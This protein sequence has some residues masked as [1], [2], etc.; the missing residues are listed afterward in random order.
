MPY[1]FTPIHKYSTVEHPNLEQMWIDSAG[2]VIDLVNGLLKHVDY[3]PNIIPIEQ[4]DNA[5]VG[6]LKQVLDENRSDK[7]GQHNYHILYSHIFNELGRSSELDVMEIGLG[8]NNPSLLSTMGS[9]ARPGASLY[10]WEQ[11]L[12]NAN[13]YGADI[14]KD[15]LFNAGRIKTAYVD[16]MKSSALSDMQIALGNK[17]Y[18]LFID[19][20][21]HAFAANFN[22]LVF[23]LDHMKPNGWIVIED[24]GK[25]VISNWYS[26]QYIL[27]Q[28]P[29]YKVYIV[30][31][32]LA[33]MFVVHKVA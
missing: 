8:T 28:N 30:D 22:S 25:R 10:A 16:Q 21:L 20:G 2:M 27:S 5:N 26:V 24:I 6:R 18:D 4:F 31:S 17:Q 15:I 19:D 13:V 12:P 1:N 9:W 33:Y 14:D 32:R 29:K 7:A 11:Y 23:A 3:T